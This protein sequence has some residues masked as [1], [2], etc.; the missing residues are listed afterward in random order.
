MH[1]QLQTIKHNNTQSHNRAITQTH[2]ITHN[3]TQ[4]Q[5]T[6]H[7]HQQTIQSHTMKHNP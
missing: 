3:H 6:T 1:T 2:T 4:S 7:N 5:T